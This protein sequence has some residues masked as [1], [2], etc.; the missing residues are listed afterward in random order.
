MQTA[1]GLQSRVSPALLYMKEQIEAGFVGEVLSC[2]QTAC[3]MVRSSA[4]Q[5]HLA[6]GVS[7]VRIL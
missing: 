5:P 2:Q 7:L 4:L 1:V 6:A 3:V